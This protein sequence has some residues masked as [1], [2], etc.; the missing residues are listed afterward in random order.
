MAAFARGF[1]QMA[2]S[3]DFGKPIAEPKTNRRPIAL[4]WKKSASDPSLRQTGISLLGEVPWGTH[5][6]L[7]YET[8]QD[9]SDTESLFFNM[10]LEKREFCVWVVHESIPIEEARDRLR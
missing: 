9:L 10:G 1:D 8:L 2:H 6:C 5:I 4:S 3:R 7:F